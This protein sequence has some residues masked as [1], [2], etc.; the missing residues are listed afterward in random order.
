M[1]DYSIASVGFAFNVTS[2]AQVK[3][4]PERQDLVN[5][6][7]EHGDLL[8]LDRLPEETNAAFRDRIMDLSVHR[9]GPTYE[10]LINNLARELGLPRYHALTIDFT[11]DSAGDPVARNPR[12]DILADRVILYE[13]WQSSDN[14]TIDNTIHFYDPD[15]EGHYLNQL[16]NQ[17]N[18]STYFTATLASDVRPNLHSANLIRRSSFGRILQE[19]IDSIHQNQLSYN[20]IVEGSLWFEERHIFHTEV[21]TDPAAEGEYYV[22]Y[23]RSFVISYDQPSG[24][25]LCGYMFNDFPMIVDAS[26]V[27]VYSLQDENFTNKLFHAEATDAGTVYGLPNREGAEIYHQLFKETE[28]FWG[29]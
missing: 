22:D 16:I 17:I 5:R 20:Y 9:G 27:H 25:G 11:R 1:A 18:T 13:N 23:D 4:V 8:S 19:A 3:V 2:V 21:T 15:S 12:V 24:D 7:D 29:E 6:F 28:V 26:L 10:G 14:Y